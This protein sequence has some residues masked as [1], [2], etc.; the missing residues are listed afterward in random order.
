MEIHCVSDFAK[1]LVFGNPL[2]DK[3]VN[4][5]GDP[6][7]IHLC[8]ENRVIQSASGRLIFCNA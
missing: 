3:I 7:E 2:A 4:A 5:K 1:G 8:A 6:N